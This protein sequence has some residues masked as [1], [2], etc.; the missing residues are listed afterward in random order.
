MAGET[1]T[2]RLE[3]ISRASARAMYHWTAP[4]G[5]RFCV[6]DFGDRYLLREFRPSGHLMKNGSVDVHEGELALMLYRSSPSGFYAN[7]PDGV[8]RDQL[9]YRLGPYHPQVSKTYPSLEDVKAAIHEALE[10]DDWYEAC[11]EERAMARGSTPQLPPSKE[12]AVWILRLKE[13]AV[14]DRDAPELFRGML[15]EDGPI[16][17]ETQRAWLAYLNGPSA[18]TWG[19]VAN[20]VVMGMTGETAWQVWRRH[21]RTA[22]GRP[23]ASHAPWRSWP[24]PDDMRRHLAQSR[25]EDVREA[26]ENI[27]RLRELLRAQGKRTEMV[28]QNLL[29][30]TAPPA[31]PGASEECEPLKAA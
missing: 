31:K 26:R 1:P 10:A 6:V 29:E 8:Q 25:E 23:A 19:A 15:S 21:D 7:L 14:G 11:D 28:E 27:V 20:Q 5:R 4:N 13:L 22:P 12:L 24:S 17:A 30:V 16:S 3:Q 9:H 18:E 2:K